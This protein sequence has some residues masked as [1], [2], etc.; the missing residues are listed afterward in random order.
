[1]KKIFLVLLAASLSVAAVNA[2]DCEKKC[3]KKECA[4]CTAECKD[5]C[6]EGDKNCAK[7][8]ESKENCCSKATAA[9]K[10]TVKA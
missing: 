9:K 6:K 1:M 3:D 7:K 8:C 4:K 2:Q 5:K 10:K